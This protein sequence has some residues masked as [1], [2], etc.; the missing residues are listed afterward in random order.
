MAQGVVPIPGGIAVP[1]AGRLYLSS[2]DGGL[3]VLDAANGTLLGRA[4]VDAVPIVA[5]GGDILAV[6]AP[7]AEDPGEIVLVDVDGDRPAVRWRTPLID[8]AAHAEIAQ[9]LDRVDLGADVRDAVVRVIADV[10]RRYRGGA[11]ASDERIAAARRNDR[12][13]IVVDR[14]SGDVVERTTTGAAA[15]GGTGTAAP[16]SGDRT[17]RRRS[18]DAST[19]EIVEEASGRTV[20][21]VTLDARADA[22]ALV[23]DAIVYRVAESTPDGGSVRHSLHSR[24]I[25]AGSDGWSHPLGETRQVPRPPLPP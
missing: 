18:R 17:L 20:A 5:A 12:H 24:A 1:A 10:H 15:T 3:E 2:A 16:A 22:A 11:H 23:G 7:T 13:V 14:G 6:R 25:D 9:G 21:D 8:A 19:W 4:E